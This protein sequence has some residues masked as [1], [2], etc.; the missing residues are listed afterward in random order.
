M[1]RACA[2]INRSWERYSV[3]KVLMDLMAKG[4]EMKEIMMK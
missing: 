1:V 3:H 4:K 2:G